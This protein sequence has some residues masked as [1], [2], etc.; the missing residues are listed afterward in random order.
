VTELR[1]GPTIGISAWRERR[2]AW[3]PWCGG[4]RG[5][6]DAATGSCEGGRKGKAARPGWPARPTGPVRDQMANGPEKIE[7]NFEFDF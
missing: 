5:G 6:G 1:R 7:I 4:A 2:A 3:R